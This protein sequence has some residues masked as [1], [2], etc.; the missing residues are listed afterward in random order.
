MSNRVSSVKMAK[1]K[2][3]RCNSEF[4]SIAPGQNLSCPFCGFTKACV[5]DKAKEKESNN[6]K[7]GR[8]INKQYCIFSQY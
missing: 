5:N 8:L 6:F 7:I 3:S 2:C 4:Y 1:M